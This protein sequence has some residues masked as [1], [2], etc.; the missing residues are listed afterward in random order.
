MTERIDRWC[1]D[2]AYALLLCTWIG[3]MWFFGAW[4]QWWFWPFTA[5]IFAAT[6]CLAV[7]M[8]LAARLGSGRLALTRLGGRLLFAYAPFLLYALVRAVQADVRMDAERSFLLQFTP[9]L[10]AV[11]VMLGVATG[12]QIPI[13]RILAGSIALIG[14]YGIVNY[15]AFHNARV[16]WVPGFPQYQLGYFR[17]TGTYFCPDHFAGLMEIGLGLALAAFL[18]RTTP[19]MERLAAC[20]LAGLTLLAIVLSKSR[21]AAAVVAAMLVMA[22]WLAPA[23][24]TAPR[25]WLWRTIGLGVLAAVVVAFALFGGNYVKRFKEYPW[26]ELQHSERFQMSAAAFRGWQEAKLFGIGPGMHQNI[27]PHIAA[28]ADG[29]REKGIWPSHL[30]N[31]FHSYEV[32]N[33][34]MQLLEEYGAVGLVLFLLALG[35]VIA[36]LLAA[37]RRQVRRWRDA[38]PEFEAGADRLVLGALFALLAM[39]VH[40]IGDFNLQ[41]PATTWLLGGL[42]GL[43]LSAAAREQEAHRRR[44][45]SSS[46]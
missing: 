20:A 14:L 4:E 41:I 45:H 13:T 15:I 1:A 17:A 10:I 32:H 8:I 39:A 42:A 11:G 37:W 9:V 30:N 40:S 44:R 16:L 29:D 23:P 7:R 33:D 28:T 27:W 38:A 35:T 6:G 18:S 12:R 22:L 21:G 3:A 34:W 5:L 46:R 19:P 26:R 31:N 25:R 24:L 36:A 2:A 43:G